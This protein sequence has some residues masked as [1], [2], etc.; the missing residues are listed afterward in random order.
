[1]ASETTLE[2]QLPEAASQGSVNLPQQSRPMEE[3]ELE[4]EQN[5]ASAEVITYPSG[6]KLWST[7][8]SLCIACFLSGLVGVSEFCR[9]FQAFSF[10]Y[11]FLGLSFLPLL[12]P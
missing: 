12:I 9:I 6:P 2:R 7:M 11:P 5:D 8:A 4:E 1:M 3:L 10:F